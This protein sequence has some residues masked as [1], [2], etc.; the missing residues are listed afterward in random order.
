MDQ[1]IAYNCGPFRLVVV[2]TAGITSPVTV[3][4]KVK[5]A[6]HVG[7]E[8]FDMML[9]VLWWDQAKSERQAL[10]ARSQNLHSQQAGGP[11]RPR[12]PLRVGCQGASQGTGFEEGVA[13][14][15]GSGYF[16]MRAPC[17]LVP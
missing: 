2:V 4:T 6:V 15:Q 1:V 12:L 10:K 5:S 13:P 16:E 11:S 9:M 7:R 14:R 3:T 8:Q 17:K